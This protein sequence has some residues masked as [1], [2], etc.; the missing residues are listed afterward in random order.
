[1]SEDNWY[2]EYRFGPLMEPFE[3]EG[4]FEIK[5]SQE[6]FLKLFDDFLTKLGEK[7]E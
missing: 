1:M 5:I 7:Q 3:D 2:F 6:A 4:L